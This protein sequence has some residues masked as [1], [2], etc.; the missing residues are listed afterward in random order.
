MAEFWK[1]VVN[2]KNNFKLVDRDN[3][4]DGQSS[5]LF[6]NRHQHLPLSHQ[7]QLLPIFKYKQQLIYC[8]ETY[9][10]VILIGETGCGKSTQLPQYLV[11]YGWTREADS[12]KG[13]TEKSIVCTQVRR[14][15]AVTIAARVASEYGC[16]VGEEVG[17][18]IRF[19][20]KCSAKTKIKYFTDGVLLRETLTDPLLSK[21][22]VIIVDEAHQRSLHSDILLGLLKKIQK[23]RPD[24]RLIITSAT[25]DA[26]PL[27]DFFET[28]D[29]SETMPQL[30]TSI[31]VSIQGRQHPVDILYLKNPT[32]N[33]VKTCIDLLLKIHIQEDPIGDVLIFLPGGEEVDT[34]IEYFKDIYE[35][36]SLYCLPL[37]SSLPNHMQMAVFETNPIGSN[38]RKAIIA[39]NIAEASITIEGIKYVIDSGFVKLNYFD[40]RTGIDAL[41]TCP[42]SKST[43]AQRA[44]RAGRTQAGKCYRL[45]NEKDYIHNCPE[46]SP[47][48]MQRVDIT[49]AVLQLKSIGIDNILRFDFLSSPTVD[50]MIYALELLYSL[51]AIEIT[52]DPNQSD[53]SKY[54]PSIGGECKLTK[55]GL[56][57]ANMP[58][59]PRLAKCLLSSFDFGCVEEMLTIAAMCSVDY[60]FITIR[61]KGSI[62]S[63]QKLQDNIKEL[64]I[65]NSDHLTLLNIYNKFLE[66][67]YSNSWCDSNSLQY[68]ILIRAKE[69]RQSLV[70]IVKEYIRLSDNGNVI[71]SCMDD[72][73]AIKRCLVSGYFSYAAKLGNDGFY[74][75]VRGDAVVIPHYTSVLSKYGLPAEWII[76]NEIFLSKTT[77]IR[78]ITQIE[79]LWLVELANHYYDLKL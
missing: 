28:N 31:I 50:S 57:M 36:N 74:H 60:P 23:K 4:S 40:V 13:I 2:N 25:L 75:T 64:M 53:T 46:H 12:L 6:H 76:F 66:S 41:I 52:N 70:K 30:N 39:T 1:P 38:I 14:V 79:P 45:M 68:R 18:A 35:G 27:Q 24:L 7:R 43:A 54:N 16:E 58:I 71:S 48:E 47:V 55:I 33:Y 11:E 9:R 67:G 26:K 69:I 21:Y 37:Y 5:V 20:Y 44:G 10:T 72:S 51:H 63:K 29:N 3:Q 59:E 22:S 73:K 8:V 19:D 62:E 77:Q 42:I 56:F 78:E 32:R 65:V 49:W 61:S 15:A 34:A 17:Y